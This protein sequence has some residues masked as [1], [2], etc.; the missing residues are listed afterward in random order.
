M[1]ESLLKTLDLNDGLATTKAMLK[2][3][4]MQYIGLIGLDGK[5]KVKAFEFKFEENGKLYFDT[6]RNKETHLE[7]LNNPYVEIS[8]ADGET[9][10]WIRISGKVKF[11]DDQHIKEKLF[12]TSE[13]L[14]KYYG[15][16][17]NPDVLPFC[18][19]DV[20]VECSSL[21]KEVG[22]HKYYL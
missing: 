22:L 8:V 18:L 14:R 9:F 6:I 20:Y 12:E 4:P 3:Y 19:E 2:A 16:A 1:K 5:P 15:D 21:D 17:S 13:I 7:L 10:D 11:V